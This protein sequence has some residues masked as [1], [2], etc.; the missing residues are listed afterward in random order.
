MA[1]PAHFTVKVSVSSNFTTYDL[2]NPGGTT[3]A[4]VR[5]HK[6]GWGSGF[7]PD[8][9]QIMDAFEKLVPLG[10]KITREFKK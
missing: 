3:A 7:N 8:E 10:S 5:A 1:E 9:Q 6:G 4:T 2:L